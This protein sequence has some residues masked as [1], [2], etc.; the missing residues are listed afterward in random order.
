MVYE[1][2]IDRRVHRLV[3]PFRAT[4][5]F[6]DVSSDSTLSTIAFDRSARQGTETMCSGSP[7]LTKIDQD[8]SGWVFG[9]TKA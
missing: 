4:V 9:L 8:D 6:A 7:A 3:K 5:A 1:V 2:Q